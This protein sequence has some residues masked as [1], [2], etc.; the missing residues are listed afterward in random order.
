[1]VE[2]KEW[3]PT[4]GWLNYNRKRRRNEKIKETIKVWLLVLA[5]IVAYAFFG[6]LEFG[7]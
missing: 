7:V 1:M 5:L 4:E 3:K 6:Y 2:F